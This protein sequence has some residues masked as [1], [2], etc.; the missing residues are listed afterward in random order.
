MTAFLLTSGLYAQQGLKIGL[1][2]SP[3][4]ASA[5][6]T[7]QD[8]N[9]IVENIS[10]KVGISY[11]L[12]ANYGITDNYGFH[13]GIHIVQKGF[14][15]TEDVVLPDNGGTLS[16]AVQDV[17]L[18][19]VE[20]PLALK[21]RSPEIGRGFFINGLFGGSID[22][23]AGYRNQYS[24]YNPV[25]K[26]AVAESGTTKNSKL[27]NPVA[28]SFIFGLGGE[29]EMNIGTLNAGFFYHRGLTNVNNR[30]QFGNEESIR[31]NYLSL[32]LGY[33]F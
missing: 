6:I 1:R 8:G 15:R 25:T 20:I 19:T 9:D 18:T 5:S 21:G 33:Y 4:F 11:G 16:N 17:R 12:M 3:I 2:F 26:Q 24:V 32:D 22:I 14:K 7:D 28:L 13:S 31:V 27:A 30:S 29:Y 10:T 23:T